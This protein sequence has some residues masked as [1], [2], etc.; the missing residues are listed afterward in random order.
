MQPLLVAAVLVLPL[1]ALG[2]EPAAVEPAPVAV[3]VPT[4][5]FTVEPV[6]A[7]QPVHAA[8]PVLPAWNIGGGFT[9][10]TG[11]LAML[12]SGQSGLVGSAGALGG[13][14]QPTMTLLLERR[15]NE[16]LFVTFQ[17]SA[18]YGASQDDKNSEV[19]SHQLS[20]A[21]TIGLRRVINPR[22]IVEVSWFANLGLGYGN[23]ES[24][25][26][27]N[28]YNPTTGMFLPDAL[29]IAR[30][31]SFSLGAVAGL[32]LERELVAG[33]ALRLSSSVLGFSYGSGAS[34]LSTPDSSSDGKSH[35]FNLGLRFSPS[36]EIRYAF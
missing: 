34:S 13:L 23:F 5:V 25:V 18:G 7:P 33:L 36:I 17:A 32:T 12:G 14:S 35:G 28:L 6:P 4:P 29:Q 26:T 11:G 3:V 21:G 1:I 30:G 10:F 20:L 2:Q 24:R 22:G 31:N 15:L 8:A 27:G 19:F 9:F 16:Y